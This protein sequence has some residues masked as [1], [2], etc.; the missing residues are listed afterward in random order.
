VVGVIAPNF[1]SEQF[2]DRPGVW[3]PFQIDP[4]A[5]EKGPLCY[6]TGRLRSDVTVDAAQAELQI[7]TKNMPRPGEPTD[8]SR[9]ALA[10]PLQEA[11]VGDIRSGLLI[12]ASAVG[13]VLL[14]ACAN[15]AG[16][17]LI[18]AVDQRRDVAI[19]AAIGAARSRIARQVLFES[20]VMALVSGVL[21]L[22]LGTIA[23][24]TLLAAY[25]HNNN[26]GIVFAQ[27]ASLPRIN[28]DSTGLTMDGRV[29]MFAAILSVVTG[30]LSGSVPAFQ[31]GRLDLSTAL[32]AGRGSDERPGGNRLRASI[33]AGQIALT[34]TLLTGSGL[35]I[36]TALAL[37]AV[38]RGFDTRN[39]VSL[40][41]AVNGTRFQTRAGIEQL[42]RGG[43]GRLRAIPGITAASV[44]CCVPLETV[45]Q[46]PFIVDGRP[47]SGRWHGFAGW[48]FV[49]SG[50]FETLNVPLLRGR[51][52]SER[53]DAG[54]AAVAII[55]EAMARRFWPDGDP[56]RDQLLMGRGI[57]AEFQNDPARQIIGIVG[58]VRDQALNRAARPIMYVPAGQLPDGVTAFEVQ[59][60]PLTWLIRTSVDG[61]SLSRPIE[62]ELQ[63]A[64]GGLPVS[65]MRPMDE[66]VAQSIGRTRFTMAMM[67][68]FACLSLLLAVTG[69][70]GMISYSVKSRIREIGIRMALGAAPTMVLRAVLFRVTLLVAGGVLV[71]TLISLWASRFMA[72][73]LYGLEARDAPTLIGA[74]LVLS[75]AGV[76]AGGLPAWR[77]A[78]V[79]P[80]EIFRA[81]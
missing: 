72:S 3:I 68:T 19:R 13:C 62:R 60:L 15:V 7:V 63:A 66:V 45:W 8:V 49:S 59:Q 58:D 61:Q 34:L 10:V 46:L 78:K 14:I 40:Q 23:T 20:L 27:L 6:V 35:L 17:L 75:M 74:I 54:G 28:H 5:P 39:V 47:L 33:V 21:A 32:K 9:S 79:D 65:R 16:L 69:I 77:A 76:V 11:M 31:A 55:N 73:L 24:K 48:T 26:S 38:H 57:H 25:P 44:A 81:E 1:D 12:L 29:W 56:L 2:A 42:S 51:T 52:F 67:S 64:S 18:R 50:Y 80:A 37:L 43:L 70:Y 22:F 53:D 71:G 36:R 4:N 30:L 41:M